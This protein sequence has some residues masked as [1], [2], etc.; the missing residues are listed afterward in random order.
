MVWALAKVKE[1]FSLFKGKDR[2]EGYLLFS[3]PHEY[4]KCVDIRFTA[5]RVVCNNTLT[6]ALNQNSEMMVRLNHCRK[7]DPDMVKQTLGIASDRL[8]TMRNTFFLIGEPSAP[9][10]PM[11][12]TTAGGAFVNT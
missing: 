1:E 8:S 5:T 12:T 4:G 9:F 6:L 11:R 3:N 10:S 2:V 7:F